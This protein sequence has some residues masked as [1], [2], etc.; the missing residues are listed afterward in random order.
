MIFRFFG[1]GI[2]LRII[3][4]GGPYILFETP[5]SRIKL[6]SPSSNSFNSGRD[7]ISF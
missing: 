4:R 1:A 7:K 6:I 2:I 5:K 3:F